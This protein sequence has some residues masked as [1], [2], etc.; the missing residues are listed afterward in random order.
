MFLA[1]LTDSLNPIVWNLP[2]NASR[3]FY[4]F[5]C[6]EFSSVFDLM[7]AANHTSSPERSAQYLRHLQDERRHT[8]IF[9]SRANKIQSLRGKKAFPHP[10]PHYEELFQ[11]LG[12]K[13]FLAFVHLGETRGCIQFSSYAKYF[14]KKNDEHTAAIFNAVLE[15]ETQHMN[16][17]WDLL[18]E[19]CGNEADA[20]IAV[21]RARRWEMRRQWMRAGR[22]LTNRLFFIITISVYPLFL[23]Y[24][25]LSMLSSPQ[26]R[27]RKA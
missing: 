12:E 2:G 26:S 14:A 9:L 10:L 13:Q 1:I 17:T 24:K 18:V 11:L 20:K 3:K 21:A 19:L 15:D 25:I 7:L 16:Y 8:N 23:P 5:S 6:T 22:A 27:L 4:S